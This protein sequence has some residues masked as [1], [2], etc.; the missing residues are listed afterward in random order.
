[1][2]V[3]VNIPYTYIHMF[4]SRIVWLTR[5]GDRSVA[6]GDLTP[7][8]AAAGAGGDVLHFYE[9]GTWV[10][11]GERS[12]AISKMVGFILCRLSMF[13]LVVKS[14]TL[15]KHFPITCVNQIHGKWCKPNPYRYIY[16]LLLHIMYLISC[17]NH[18]TY[19]HE[20]WMMYCNFSLSSGVWS[21][22]TSHCFVFLKA[23]VWLPSR[24]L[25]KGWKRWKP[26]KTRHLDWGKVG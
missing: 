24:C 11:M 7:L 2:F 21:T 13:F 8:G 25:D 26:T 1:M 15:P 17:Q 14:S 6:C 3:E 10:E 20:H 4:P 18:M 5:P 22:F 23:P 9:F 12:Q 16:A 19:D